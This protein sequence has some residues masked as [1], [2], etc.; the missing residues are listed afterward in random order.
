M[1]DWPRQGKPVRI[2]LL[3]RRFGGYNGKCKRKIFAARLPGIRA[4]RARETTRLAEIVGAV[5]YAWGRVRVWE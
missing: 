5:G 4:P 3:V 1:R 2:G